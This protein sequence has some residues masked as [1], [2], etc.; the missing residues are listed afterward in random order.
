MTNETITI[1]LCSGAASAVVSGFFSV[2]LWHLNNKKKVDAHDEAIR[3]G[4]RA[5]LYDKI[6]YLGLKLIEK[7]EI[8]AEELEDIHRLHKVYHDELAG[9]GYLDTIMHKVDR[10]PVTK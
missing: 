6:K 2:V 5:L 4:V 1:L 7:G 8:T 3:A 10:L 9:N